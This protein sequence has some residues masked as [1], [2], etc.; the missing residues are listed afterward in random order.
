MLKFVLLK[1]RS[2]IWMMLALLIGCVLLFSITCSSAQ[3]TRASLQR[4]LNERLANYLQINNISPGQITVVANNT[5]KDMTMVQRTAEAVAAM[6]QKFGLPAA[7]EIR[8]YYVD[9]VRVLAELD[10]DNSIA[11][12]VK[13]GTL[14]DLEDHVEIIAGRMYNTTPDEA[15]DVDVIVSE[16]GMVDMN[17][18][19]GE[20]FI[21]TTMHD[22]DGNPLRFRV[23]GVFR[24]SRQND[25]YWI[26]SPESLASECFLAW[27]VFENVFMQPDTTVKF[28]ARF[29]TLL[30]HSQMQPDQIPHLL[31]TVKYYEKEFGRSS[32]R[33]FWNAFSE[34]LASFQVAQRQVTVTI[35]VLQV[36]IFMLLAAFIFMISK[37]LLDMEQNEIAVLKS[38]GASRFQL[39]AT[40]L[41]QSLVIAVL[42][43]AISIPLG[44][45]LVQV[46]GSANSFLEFVGRTALP[47]DFDISV[48]L[49]LLIAFV[50]AI[51]TMVLPVFR[52][53]NVTIV[54]HM[55]KKHR[56]S[57]APLWQK[58]FL[59]V[60]ILAVALYGL[61]SYSNQKDMLAQ[62]VQ[63][64]SSMDPLLFLCSS[65]FMI[66]AALLSLRILPLITGAIF[67]LFKRWWSPAL[68]TAFLRVIRTR[69]NQTFIVVFLILTVALGIFNTQAARTINTNEERNIRYSIGADLVLEEKWKDN[70]A[71]RKKDPSLPL[72]YTEPAFSRYTNLEGVRSATKVFQTNKAVVNMAHTGQV[73]NLNVMGIHTKTFGE[74]AHIEDGLLKHHFYEYL[75][76][77]SQ[78]S[79]AILVSRNF[80]TN[81]DVELGSTLRYYLPSNPVFLEGIVCGFVDY[82]PGYSPTVY[83]EDADGITKEMDNF[84]IVANLDQLQKVWGVTPYQVWIDAEDSTQF[85][86][87]FAR[88]EEVTFLSVKDTSAQII[89]MKNDPVFQ[90]TNG[91]LTVGFVVVLLLCC[92]GFLIYW[93]LSIR[94]RSLQFGIYRAMGMSMREILSILVCEQIFISGTAIATGAGVGFLTSALY[95]PLIQMA[96][97]S[98]DTVL[99]LQ[100]V[101]YQ[102]DIVRLFAVVGTMILVCMVIL[103]WLISRMKITQALKL[104]ED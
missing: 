61:F 41:T 53:A 33:T 74:T 48:V 96:F 91:I 58:M 2:K 93:I 64:G 12:M 5:A 65:L 42:A 24:N 7:M 81:Y 62:Q 87:D 13:L 82:W 32:T 89:E 6:P 26:E 49:A 59:D 72:I 43:M 4:S 95:M 50:F 39:I 85:I 21:A 99:P 46:L 68:Y 1:I 11:G 76:A 18:L 66:G 44:V 22:S 97:A 52:H 55:Q 14:S 37:Q 35:W 73:P 45:L 40:Y 51:C 19:L 102:S 28:S 27:D 20:H 86:Y 90:G 69:H 94:S 56:K 36:P 17:F 25:P 38:R 3:Y 92:V 57:Q 34:L 47:I 8:H 54:N 23:C 29:F 88:E 67:H 16:Q 63:K 10:R 78:D 9:S 104:G 103:G 83:A 101:S 80:Q 98:Y 79:R 84:L 15:G 75:N 100:I 31:E 77:M 30:D 60:A 71:Q 70:S